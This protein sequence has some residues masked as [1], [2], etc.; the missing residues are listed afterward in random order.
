M[1]LFLFFFFSSRRRHTRFD[2]DWSSDVCS[3]DLISGVDKT[4]GT[5][6]G[7]PAAMA[8]FWGKN[9]GVVNLKL[10][11]AASGWAVDKTAT[12]T[13]TLSTQNPDKTY[14]A[15]DATIAPLVQ[16][17][18][19]ATIAYVRP[20]IGPSDS[21]LSPYFADAG[22]VSAIQVVNQAQA[23]YVKAYVNPTLPQYSSLP[24]L[25][26]SAPFKS[27]FAGGT[28]YTDVPIG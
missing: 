24:V 10:K 25:S 4:A 20:P 11:Y 13:A 22:D 16:A 5:V 6:S 3:S 9:L 8:N 15:A 27:G 26:V 21:R 12:T 7:V 18:H 28:D 17:E 1:L 14:V 19:Q 23:T 2:C